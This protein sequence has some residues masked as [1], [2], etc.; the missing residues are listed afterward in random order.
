MT[1]YWLSKLFYDLQQP[2]MA[3]AYRANRG[4]VLKT[5]PLAPEVCEALANDDVAQLASRV[6]PYLLRFYFGIIGMADAEFV[7]QIRASGG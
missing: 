4:E 1:D 7:K 6:N 5:Y 3:A 2:A